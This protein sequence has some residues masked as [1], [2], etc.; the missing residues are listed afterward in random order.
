M[1]SLTAWWLPRPTSRPIALAFNGL[2]N[3]IRDAGQEIEE[4]GVAE[5]GRTN[6]VASNHI[7]EILHKPVRHVARSQQIPDRARKTTGPQVQLPGVDEL[8]DPERQLGDR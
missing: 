6:R 4:I 5:A 7:P 3:P 2:E 1:R 8:V